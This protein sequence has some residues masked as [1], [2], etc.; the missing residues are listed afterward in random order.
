MLVWPEHGARSAFFRTLLNPSK[1]ERQGWRVDGDITID[2]SQHRK[3]KEGHEDRVVLL[4]RNP[5]SQL[6]SC[7]LSP[8][9]EFGLPLALTGHKPDEQDTAAQFWLSAL[10]LQR[11]AEIRVDRLSTG[12]KQR[13]L[14]ASAVAL[15][16]KLLLIDGPIEF[17]DAESRNNILELLKQYAIAKGASL[18]F[19]AS[20]EV[21]VRD[22][23]FDQ[24][25]I[26]VDQTTRTDSRV[27]SRH[28]LQE[29]SRKHEQSL[30]VSE[31]K[32]DVPTG[33]L[34]LY[35][36]L[37]FSVPGGS[38]VV[39]VGANGCGKSTLGHLIGGR[40]GPSH[41]AIDVFGMPAQHWFEEKRPQ[42]SISFP[43][44]DLSLTGASVS[45]EIYAGPR[46]KIDQQTM[47]AIISLLQ[48]DTLLG[49]NPFDLEWHVR[50]RVSMAK[51][52]ASAIEGVFIDEPAADASDDERSRLIEVLQ[53]CVEQELAVLVTTNDADLADALPFDVI[54][55]RPPVGLSNPRRAKRRVRE[56]NRIQGTTAAIERQLPWERV[57][58]SRIILDWFERAPEFAAFWS[59]SV[60]PHLRKHLASIAFRRP[61]TLVDLG[62]GHGLHTLNVARILTA[63]GLELRSVLGVDSEPLLIRVAEEM[64]SGEGARRFKAVDLTDIGDVQQLAESL[65]SEGLPILY[66]ALFSLHDMSTLRALGLLFRGTAILGTTLFAS[67][68]SP[69]Y[70]AAAAAAQHL[71]IA[72]RVDRTEIRE[73]TGDA[74]WMW[75]G[76]FPVS[77]DTDHQ[78]RI[79]YFH[80]DLA[81]YT[82]L[83]QSYWQHVDVVRE[84]LSGSSGASR[85]R[86]AT[87]RTDDVLFLRG[88]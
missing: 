11:V 38:G 81:N 60:Y 15:S 36:G 24:V 43:D 37:S 10:G 86:N 80:R 22:A 67:L 87:I 49:V 64:S 69:Q 76:L 65:R 14:L 44:P 77:S 30:R 32:Y 72:D 7:V 56:L 42:I 19:A 53:L 25:S 59:S 75:R 66:T 46:G 5:D 17:V 84:V 33:T 47:D 35:D 28:P 51:A 40:I 23:F 52:I 88:Y 6:S 4:S 18:L 31:L 63:D 1:R 34:S 83:L 55:I 70:V 85:H 54:R 20:R 57:V 68:V 3:S 82:L 73:G 16:P 74:D 9:L 8:V 27:C 78:L 61:F 13:L 39:L 41:G 26:A 2:D 71:D 29:K 48:L 21:L 50:R 45:D 12:Q 62:C 58:W 79:P